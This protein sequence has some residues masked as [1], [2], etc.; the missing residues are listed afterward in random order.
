MAKKEVKIW[1]TRDDGL[2]YCYDISMEKPQRSLGRVYHETDISLCPDLWH[3]LTGIR[4]DKGQIK[5]V[6]ITHL[7]KGFKFEVI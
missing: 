2:S 7:K 1:L 3:K 5:Q 4:L 6:K